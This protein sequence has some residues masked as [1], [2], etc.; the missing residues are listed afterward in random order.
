MPVEV[1]VPYHVPVTVPVAMRPSGNQVVYG[2]PSHHHDSDASSSDQDQIVLLYDAELHHGNDD[3]ESSGSDVPSYHHRASPFTTA[4]RPLPSILSPNK[5]KFWRELAAA[6]HAEPG[7][8]FIPVAIASNDAESEQS[9][10]HFPSGP[11][12][13]AEKRAEQV[14]AESGHQ[15]AFF[16]LAEHD[17]H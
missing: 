15:P 10:V 11:N 12:P 1:P 9:S 6:K 13:V 14:S 5:M 2:H 16:V 4:T 7:E 8:R 17:A 3:L